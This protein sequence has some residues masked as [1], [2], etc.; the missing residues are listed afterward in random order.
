MIALL[1]PNGASKSTP[2]DA[3]T[4]LQPTSGQ[5]LWR[6]TRRGGRRGAR[7]IGLL[8]HD[9][10]VYPGCRRPRTSVLRPVVLL[11]DVGARSEALEQAEL[12]HGRDDRSAASR[13]ACGG[14]QLGARSCTSGSLLDEPFTGLDDATAALRRRCRPSRRGL[15]R[16]RDHARSR[17]RRGA[18]RSRADAPQRT[19]GD[20]RRRTRI[21]ARPLPPG[22][23]R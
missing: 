22:H 10:Y 9:L 17:D 20:A 21:V 8:G 16:P 14:P 7:R 18:D 6:S 13:A 11:S 15:H 2:V 23:G 19:A 12:S 1:G 5:V 4:L 3:A